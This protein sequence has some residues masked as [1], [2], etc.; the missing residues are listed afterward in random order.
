MS[1]HKVDNQML[2]K[3]W[4]KYI[5]HLLHC[6]F[7]GG[8]PGYLGHYNDAW[9]RYPNDG[10]NCGVGAHV[11]QRPTIHHGCYGHYERLP[12]ISSRP[13][14]VSRPYL[15]SRPCHVPVG[16]P[17][18]PPYNEC[19]CQEPPKI[20]CGCPEKPKIDCGCHG[21]A[22]LPDCSLHH[23]WPDWLP[24]PL[25]FQC[26]KGES[27]INSFLVFCYFLGGHPH[28]I[29]HGYDTWDHWGGPYEGLHWGYGH[30]GHHG[31]GGYHYGHSHHYDHDAIVLD[32]PCRI[33]VVPVEIP[34]HVPC[35]QEHLHHHFDYP[36]VC[37]THGWPDCLPPPVPFKCCK[38]R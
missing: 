22:V 12:V 27:L 26:C 33:P 35:H 20:E 13:C 38:G 8:Y 2:F 7:L 29:G 36:G 14:L 4:D 19:G 28:I 11:Y 31:C 16:L 18:L 10:I 34:H 17:I 24:P 23:G 30:H 25:P 1:K 15:V 5:T 6:Y 37:L 32:N 21:E 9:G 3:A